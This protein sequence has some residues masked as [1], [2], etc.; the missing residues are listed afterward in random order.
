MSCPY[1]TFC[2]VLNRFCDTRHLSQGHFC[3]KALCWIHQA[4]STQTD[5]G[6]PSRERQDVSPV[7]LLALA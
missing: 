1:S 2:L 3:T 4:S 7:Q 5:P 6:F